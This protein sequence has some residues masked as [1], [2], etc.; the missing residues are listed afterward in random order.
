MNTSP[1]NSQPGHNAR[2]TQ[3]P[4]LTQQRI[5]AELGRPETPEE[6][7]ARKAE[8][9]RKHRANQ[10]LF[11]LVLALAASLAIVLFLVLVVVRP[12]TDSAPRVDYQKVAA[13]AQPTVSEPLASPTL[14]KDWSANSA[15][16]RKGP[17]GVLSWTIG[18]IT[19]T[20]QYIGLVQ[21]VKAN[22]SWISNQVNGT[23][24]TGRQTIDGIE[25]TTYDRRSASAQAGKDSDDYAYSMTATRGKSSFVLHGSADDS[26]FHTLAEALATQLKN[27]ANN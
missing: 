11:N 8:N 26:E 12:S 9:S 10:T 2:P 27:D 19:P 20:P 22:P 3:I 7:A 21:G 17:D 24:P 23:R 4:Q 25:W 18:F 6:T 14:P 16:L 5:V 15:R 13:D 1:H